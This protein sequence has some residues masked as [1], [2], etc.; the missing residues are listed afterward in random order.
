MSQK[1]HSNIVSL[2]WFPAKRMQ[3]SHRTQRTH[4]IQNACVKFNAALYATNASTVKRLTQ[5][6][7]TVFKMHASN[8]STDQPQSCDCGQRIAFA[9]GCKP[10][11]RIVEKQQLYKVYYQY[12]VNKQYW[13]ERWYVLYVMQP[14]YFGIFKTKMTSYEEQ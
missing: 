9:F 10:P 1:Q 5:A 13:G 7:R 11:L 2:G 4:H 12:Y 14:I 6:P 3:R 8:A